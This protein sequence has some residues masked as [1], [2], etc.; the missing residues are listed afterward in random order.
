MVRLLTTIATMVIMV[1]SAGLQVQAQEVLTLDDCINIALEKRASIIMARGAEQS[2]S[3]AKRS[4]LG[5]FL[6]GANVSYNYSKGKETSI[7]PANGG[8]DE[9]DI[10][11]RKSWSLRSGMDLVNISNF[12]NYAGAAA[13]KAQAELDVL[14]SENDM[15]FAVKTA[16]YAYLAM[17]ENVLVQ[18][19]AVK[20]ADEQLKL[21]ESRFELGSAALSDVLKQKVQSGNDHLALLRAKNA[22]TNTKAD[23]AYTIGLDPRQEYVFSLDYAV[24][25]YSGSLSEAINLGLGGN[26]SLLSL[27]KTVDQSNHAVKAAMASY[28]PRIG[29]SFDYTRFE[30]T[31]AFPFSQDYSSNA[32]TYGFSISLN[33]FDGFLREKRVSDAKVWRNNARANEADG[34]NKTV[35]DIKTAY[36]D[37]EQL[38]EQKVVSD[39]NVEAAEEDL[40]ITQEKYN[41]GAATI[42]EI[43]ESQEALKKAQV[44]LIQV[45]FDNNLAVA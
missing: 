30:G 43:L 27:N 10:G 42:L 31:V 35:A 17:E 33:V 6:P 28:L 18:G 25:Q 12:Y 9:Q 7:E 11:P 45:D 24:S 41:L 40:K 16:Y 38:A 37:I 32:Y 4:A 2:A 1:G 22:V 14:S 15:R 8:I 39:G 5:A 26:P 3:A 21:I 29:G 44:S 34:R 20:R 13:A 36:L 23:L 19:D